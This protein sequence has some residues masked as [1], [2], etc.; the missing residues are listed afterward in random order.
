MVGAETKAMAGHSPLAVVL[1]TRGLRIRTMAMHS[2]LEYMTMVRVGVTQGRV[3]LWAVVLEGEAFLQPGL[4]MAVIRTMVMYSSLEYM[5][6][7]RV[8]A[9]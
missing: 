6:T 2:S 7:V 3:V 8:E 5:A 1:E 9:T 4:Q